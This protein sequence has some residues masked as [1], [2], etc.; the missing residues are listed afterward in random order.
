MRKIAQIFVA[1]SEKLNLDERY[2]KN[3]FKHFFFRKYMN[4]VLNVQA[5]TPQPDRP[6]KS[7]IM[8]I[9]IEDKNK[10]NNMQGA[11]H[12]SIY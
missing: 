10:R 11:R 3:I 8:S 4:L 5:E 7:K 6:E 1:F 12:T 9:I 2:Q